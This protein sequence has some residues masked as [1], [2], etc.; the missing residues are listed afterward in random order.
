MS[1]NLIIFLRPWYWLPTIAAAVGGLV[2]SHS[3]PLTLCRLA[4]VLLASGPGLSAFAETI[5]EVCDVQLDRATPAAFFHKLR[6]SGGSG[7]IASGAIPVSV[8]WTVVFTTALVGLG[9]AALLT[10]QTLVVFL[11]GLC[12]AAIYS[13]SPIRLKKRPF[14]GMLAQ[15]LGYGPVA[16]LIG[17]LPAHV[18]M[19]VV[20]RAALIGVWIGGAGMTADL[21]DCD[22]DSAAGVQ[23]VPVYLGRHRASLLIVV[24][25]AGALV[26]LSVLQWDA[27]LPSVTAALWITFAAWAVSVWR[28]RRGPLPAWTHAFTLAMEVGVPLYALL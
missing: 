10:I 8:A 13:L 17:Y 3:G 5:N 14:L 7:L 27:R 6:L 9:A 28:F 12:L 1:G 23:T 4:L 20:E 16:V 2:Y 22:A 24:M 15:I 11:F 26:G 21:L 25:G 19:A 18:D